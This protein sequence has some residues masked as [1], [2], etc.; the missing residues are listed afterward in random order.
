MTRNA[1]KSGG[2]ALE[3][4][5]EDEDALVDDGVGAFFSA[6]RVSKEHVVPEKGPASQQPPQPDR[7]T[8]REN[9]I[10]REKSEEP[11]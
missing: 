6:P 1:V 9:E 4:S 11:R 3:R 10:N 7:V 2:V 5:I 8:Q